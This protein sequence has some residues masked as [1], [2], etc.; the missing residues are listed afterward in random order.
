MAWSEYGGKLGMKHG[1]HICHKLSGGILS[2]M[3]YEVGDKFLLVLQ[4]Q[5]FCH[6]NQF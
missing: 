2:V 6:L 3:T 1:Y 5:I 4:T